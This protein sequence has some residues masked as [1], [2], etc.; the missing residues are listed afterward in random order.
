LRFS[1]RFGRDAHNT[2]VSGRWAFAILRRIDIHVGAFH[3]HGQ[4]KGR[5]KSEE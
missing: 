4:K 5:N 3:V 1:S 2:L